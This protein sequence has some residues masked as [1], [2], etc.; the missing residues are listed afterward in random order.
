MKGV[1][2]SSWPPKRLEQLS[3]NPFAFLAFVA[4]S[5]CSPSCFYFSSSSSVFF[6]SFFFFSCSQSL[7]RYPDILPEPET[8][9]Q[10]SDGR[11][12]NANFVRDV[13][14]TK[15]KYIATQGPLQGTASDFWQM[16]WEHRVPVVVM[17]AE[18][19][20]GKATKV[21]RYFPAEQ[22]QSVQVGSFV[23][24]LARMELLGNVQCS[25]LHVQCG[26]D[27][28][29]IVHYWYRGWPDNGVPMTSEVTRNEK[30][31]RKKE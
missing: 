24:T 16:V 14:G 18:F 5:I 27:I 8:R 11:Y 31:K 4:F 25:R 23:V 21:A 28:R 22:G 13:T 1:T 30:K 6:L 20:E 15:W 3:P 2:D 26:A 19:V 29:E 17:A 7:N 10:L 12:I 9:V